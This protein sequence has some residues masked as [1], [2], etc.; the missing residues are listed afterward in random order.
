MDYELKHSIIETLISIIIKPKY[1]KE[2]LNISY[3]NRQSNFFKKLRQLR[4]ENNND[5]CKLWFENNRK[6]INLLFKKI[7]FIY[8]NNNISFKIPKRILF[9]KF[10]EFLYNKQNH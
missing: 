8:D 7:I 6:E 4:V 3:L 2:E 10:V 1:T 5:N 9:N